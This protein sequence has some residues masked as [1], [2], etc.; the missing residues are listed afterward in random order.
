VSSLNRHLLRP[1]RIRFAWCLAAVVGSSSGLFVEGVPFIGGE[2]VV[3]AAPSDRT[4]PSAFTAVTPCRLVD[5]RTSRRLRPGTTIDVA[6]AERCGVTSDAVVAAVTIT[7][8]APDGDGFLTAFP[9]DVSRPETSVV[10]YRR[11]EVIANHQFVRLGEGGDLS[12]FS[13]AAA[14]VV[15]DVTGYFTP[16]TDGRAAAG[17]F[18]PTAPRRLIDT[19]ETRRPRAGS[20]VRVDPG[21]DAGAIAVVVNI[22]TAD[23]REGGHFTAFAAGAPRPESSVLNVDRPGEI[24]AAAAVVP[25]GPKG[26]DVFTSGANHVIVDIVGYFTDESAPMSADGLFVG[27]TPTRLVDTRLPVGVGGGPRLWDRGTR[28]FA[29]GQLSASVAAI[30]ANITITQTEDVGYALAYPARSA[31][32]STSTVNTDHAQQT[33]ANF[34]VVGVSNRGVAVYSLEATHLVVDVGGWF[35][36]DPVATT[37]GAPSNRPPDDRRVTIISDSA[38]A[39][40]R[41]NGALGG[42]QGFQAVA[43]LESC[44]RLVQSS[45]RGREGYA[46]RTAYSEIE[47]LP[48]AGPEEMLVIAVGYND[49]HARFSSDFDLVIDAARRK[50]FRHIAWVDY[51]SQ[52]GY[53]LPGSG[54]T[55]SNYGEMNRILSE[56]LSSGAFPEVRRWR[57]DDY[58]SHSSGWFT[59]D[60]VHETRLGSWGV[61]DWI[62]RHVRAFDDR[63]CPNPWFPGAPVDDPCPD[64]DLVV[65]SRGVPDIA[66][67]YGL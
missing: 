10:N 46:P 54:G 23:A 47:A 3:A 50:G 44:R 25:L 19:R 27:V 49:W 36:G 34:A 62:S 1:G 21:L 35:L 11:G 58:T 66:T 51:R 42:Y 14:D 39:G 63:P 33:V 6:V 41:W 45:C 24:R 17:R 29:T 12:V 57:F 60:G 53:T 67:L 43:K 31:R 26:F 59:Y 22:T 52:V 2:A 9:S 56:K 7:A 32:P 61:T 18:I 37:T 55:R 15:V 30:A 4:E 40:V 8:V 13:L 65:A 20:T 28:E 64:P 48:P 38:M 5:T 16:A